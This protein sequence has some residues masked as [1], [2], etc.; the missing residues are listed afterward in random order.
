MK[1][2]SIA[3]FSRRLRALVDTGTVDRLVLDLRLNR[4]GDGTLNRPLLLSLIKARKLEGPGKLFVIIGRSTFSAAQFLV[5][6]LEAYTDAVF[7]GE[8]SGGKEPV[9]STKYKVQS[10]KKIV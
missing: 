10:S 4:G 8:P 3:D 1:G 5:N 6:Q 2:E 7:V 9:Q